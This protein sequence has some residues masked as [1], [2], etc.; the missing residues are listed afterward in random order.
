[1]I[2]YLEKRK[3]KKGNYRPI[4]VYYIIGK[5][6]KLS[7]QNKSLTCPSCNGKGEHYSAC[8][9][10]GSGDYFTCTTCGGSGNL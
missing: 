8:S 10:G 2:K 9:F 1:M 4:D 3:T 6:S 7:K 5:L